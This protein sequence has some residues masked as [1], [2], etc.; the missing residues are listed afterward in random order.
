MSLSKELHDLDMSEDEKKLRDGIFN[1]N[2][3]RFGKVTEFMIAKQFN[4]QVV[5]GKT[6]YDLTNSSG[7]KVEVKF[8]RAEFIEDE[9]T[10]DNCRSIC[11]NNAN[12]VSRRISYTRF[13][14]NT[15][16]QFDCNIQQIKANEFDVIYY[17]VFFEDQIAIFSMSKQDVKDRMTAQFFISKKKSPKPNVDKTKDLVKNHPNCRAEIRNSVA[18]VNKKLAE[19]KSTDNEY[20]EDAKRILSASAFTKQWQNI[21]VEIEK[22]GWTKERYQKRLLDICDSYLTFC[23]R[24]FAVAGKFKDISPFQHRGNSKAEG[25]M[26]LSSENFDWHIHESGFFCGW[27]SYK[28]L[29]KL[30]EPNI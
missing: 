16:L 29:Y 28:E 25:Q 24:E 30:L 4:Y 23:D 19:I 10:F 20:A 6:N 11:I 13:C 15:N 5:I 21:N 8:S 1:M 22:T 12:P 7:E 17:G 2:T 3:R 14:E 9:M 26:H 18:K 27:M